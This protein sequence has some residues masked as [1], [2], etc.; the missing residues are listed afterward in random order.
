[1]ALQIER[2]QTENKT[3]DKQIK[4]LEQSK[5]N[6]ELKDKQIESLT[7]ERNELKEAIEI[8]D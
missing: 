8:R 7:R 1:M 2:L 6:E 4:S 5:R 3:K